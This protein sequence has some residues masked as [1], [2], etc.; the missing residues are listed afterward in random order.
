METTNSIY[1]AAFSIIDQATREIKARQAKFGATAKF[2][3][4]SEAGENLGGLKLMMMDPR[5]ILAEQHGLKAAKA[6]YALW[7][8]GDQY[9]RAIDAAREQSNVGLA[10]EKME[11]VLE[12]LKACQNVDPNYQQGL[13]IHEDGT[14][15]VQSEADKLEAEILAGNE[16]AN[17]IQN[18]I[19]D[20]QFKLSEVEAKTEEVRSRWIRI[21]PV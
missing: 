12:A 3:M 8:K 14:A 19:H 2:S 5:S 18:Q 17:A 6:H 20:L 21:R 13:V 11:K 9:I 4:F 16:E 15:E 10:V 1:E 7:A